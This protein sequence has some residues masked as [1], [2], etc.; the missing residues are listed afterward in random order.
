MTNPLTAESQ[1]KWISDESINTAAEYVKP[2]VK[3][4]MMAILASL[5]GTVAAEKLE[6][7]VEQ[8]VNAS[9]NS[10]ATSTKW[11]VGKSSE[12]CIIS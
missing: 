9:V 10:S 11:S 6:P 4:G 7:Q 5:I 8:S 1:L 12:W 2:P 3:A